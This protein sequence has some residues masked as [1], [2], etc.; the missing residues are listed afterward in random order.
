MEE[1]AEHLILGQEWMLAEQATLDFQYNC[2]YFGTTYR[3]SAYWH[4]HRDVIEYAPPVKLTEDK[5]SEELCD[6]YEAVLNEFPDVFHERLRQPTTRLS[7]H[8]LD[9]QQQRRVPLAFIQPTTT[10]TAA[11][12][13]D[14]EDNKPAP[15][16]DQIKQAQGNSVEYQATRAR[17]H[18]LHNGQD[19]A[20]E[21][22]QR[23]LKNDYT[24][25]D[26]LIWYT[27]DNR[28]ALV[29]PLEFWPRV[30]H[31]YHDKIGHPGR[32][33]TI[34]AIRRLYYWPAL[35]APEDDDIR[36]TPIP[37][38]DLDTESEA[39]EEEPPAV[40]VRPATGRTNQVTIEDL[41]DDDDHEDPRPIQGP[42]PIT[43]L[44]P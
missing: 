18:R 28:M 42:Q 41:P 14:I 10:L 32:D 19:E 26:D 15:L 34:D 21:P 2:V 16:F 6:S 44:W 11:Q 8:P 20:T 9:H 23:T 1:M 40:P 35:E 36:L 12:I 43:G 17:W 7:T 37:R 24:V 5:V 4:S 30:I 27:K 39:D 25:R 33:E 38:P 13:D 22:W 31:E 3:Q 29:V